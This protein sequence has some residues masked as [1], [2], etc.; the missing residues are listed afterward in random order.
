MTLFNPIQRHAAA[1][2]ARERRQILPS[3]E[4]AARGQRAERDWAVL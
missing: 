4:Q 1:P 3:P 2:V